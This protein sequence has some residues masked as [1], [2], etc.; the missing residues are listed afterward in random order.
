MNRGKQFKRQAECERHA[1]MPAEVPPKIIPQEKLRASDKRL[2][3][4][5]ARIQR[6]TMN[7]LTCIKRVVAVPVFCLAVAG[8]VSAQPDPVG[9]AKTNAIA[10]TASYHGA[11]GLGSW[12]T[13]VEFKDI[14]V[15]S[16]G[17]VLYKSNFEKEG[18]NGLTL[19]GGKWSVKDGALRQ[20]AIEQ[21]SRAFLGDKSW[22]NYTVSLRAR[23]TGGQEGFAIY[24]NYL[25]AG[26]WTWF[27]FAGWTNTLAS[28]D[29][30]QAAGNW[31]TLSP[32]VPAAIQTN[33][34]YDLRIVL[35][36]A[37]IECYVN[38]NLVQKGSYLN[39]PSVGTTTFSNSA[40]SNA[41]SAVVPQKSNAS[42]SAFFNPKF[43]GAVGVGSWNTLTEFRNIVVTSNDEVLY[44]SDF[45]KEGIDS[46]TTVGG[47]WEITNGVLRQTTTEFN[48]FATIGDTNWSNYTLTFQARKISGAEGFIAVVGW[49][50]GGTHTWFNAGSWGNHYAEIYQ[51]V[52]GRRGTLTPTAP[53]TVENGK[54]YDVRVVVEGAQVS[55]YVD[56]NLVHTAI[57][58]VLVTTNAVYL[59]SVPTPD[60]H[61]LRFKLGKHEFH[62]KL[63][64]DRGGPPALEI[65]S[66]VQVSGTVQPGLD[67][68]PDSEF[69]I[70]SPSDVLL[71]KRPSWWT[72][73][74]IALFGGV[75]FVIL[76]TA[77]I[78]IAMISRK[79][80]QLLIAQG[81]LQKANDELERRV[82]RRTAALAKANTELEHE[83]ALFRTLLDNASDYIYFKDI[84]SKFV[85]CS[86][87]VCKRS[88]FT[89]E[90]IVGKTDLDIFREEH[91]LEA[92]ADELEIIR[93]GQPL[94]GKLEKEVHSDG[95]ITWVLTTKMPWRNPDGKIVGTFGISRDI[96]SIKKAEAELEQAQ[97]KLLETSRAA[98]MAEIA[99]G[100]LHNVGNVL[101]SVNV[102]TSLLADQWK[103][104]KV[105]A[106]G[107]VAALMKEH[108]GDLANFLTND[109]QGQRLAGFLGDVAEVLK[110]EQAQAL[111][112]L[113][114]LRKNVDHIKEIVAMQQ[115]YATVAGVSTIVKIPELLGDILRLT[116]TSLDRHGIKLVKEFDKNLPSINIDR[117][118]VLQILINLVRNAKHA[119][120]DSQRPDK[121][122]TLK[123]AALDG[124]MRIIV[125]DNGVGIASENMTRIFAHGF[126]TRKHGHGFGLH[127]S[128][129]AAKEMGGGLFVH[130]EGPGK[131]ATFTLDLSLAPKADSRASGVVEPKKEAAL[132]AS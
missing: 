83:Q 108:A 19:L 99:T 5:R 102:S 113:A 129:L 24:F 45:D 93:S 91:P 97:K 124:V 73:Q 59:G 44:R 29:R 128:A 6:M 127:S 49:L 90:Q 21:Q 122:V 121:Q 58:Q 119:C 4:L 40:V 65:G 23:S 34:W 14:V 100:V 96:T 27:N 94:V 62:G 95:N 92:L 20:S 74:R 53:L 17:V 71:L 39:L 61:V 41:V 117:H 12:N 10:A 106:V 1:A 64:K 98:G 125:S 3:V 123:V 47:N 46:W 131:G 112:E 104:S 7:T 72:W 110:Q 85:R 16:N 30:Q 70:F 36:G 79:N 15:S 89:H 82:Q 60:G 109:P 22:A 115:N 35:S 86:V 11:I 81:D 33:V 8:I 9:G 103:K 2:G 31:T 111:E 51:D 56:S 78:W 68:D 42:H 105:N 80:H 101:N 37:S 50:G 43:H 13:T 87:S 88:G 132:A 66:L 38:S 55:C 120:E 116:E 28:I 130:S 126:T 54:W 32:R 48:C 75:F 25:D 57:A 77:A 107:R 67:V 69:Q 76:T 26:N 118:K 18:T 84:D 114:G 63:T 52:V